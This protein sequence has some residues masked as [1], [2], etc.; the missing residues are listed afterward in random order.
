MERLLRVTNA[1]LGIIALCLVL[2]VVS[3]YRVDTAA[4]AHAQQPAGRPANYGIGDAQ[5]VYLVYV[6]PN[7]LRRPVIGQDG[8]V[9]TKP[10]PER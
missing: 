7:N 1:L 4:V 3:I 6:D 10:A 2:L 8:A 5:P 9:P